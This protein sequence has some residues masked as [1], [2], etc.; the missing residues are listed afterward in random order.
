MTRSSV[1]HDQPRAIIKNAKAL[2]GEKEF[3]KLKAVHAQFE[4]TGVLGENNVPCA[5]LRRIS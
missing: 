4:A 2:G 1:A 3:D 5:L